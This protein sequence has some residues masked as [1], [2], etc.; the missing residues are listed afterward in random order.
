MDLDIIKRRQRN[1][2]DHLGQTCTYGGQALP[3]Y[4]TSM[5][6]TELRNYGQL[7][8]TDY[9][10]SLLVMEDATDIAVGDI[11]GYSD[12]EYRV[13]GLSKTP[14]MLQTR[15]DLGAKYGAK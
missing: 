5:R 6:D 12:A 8:T 3:C 4:Q 7:Y 10:F 13:L 9:K 14:D 2:L 11:V 1:V 15:V